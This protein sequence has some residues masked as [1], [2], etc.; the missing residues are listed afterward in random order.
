LLDE[1]LPQLPNSASAQPSERLFYCYISLFLRNIKIFSG[2]EVAKIE[3][4]TQDTKIEEPNKI[5]LL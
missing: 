2:R 5:L 4:Q 1:D 3:Q